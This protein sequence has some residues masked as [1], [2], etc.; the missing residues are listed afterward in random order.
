MTKISHNAE[1]VRPRYTAI[2]ALVIDCP[3]DDEARKV[4]EQ[5]LRQIVD[6]LQVEGADHPRELHLMGLFGDGWLK[7]SGL[8]F[9]INRREDV[10]SGDWS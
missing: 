6:T 10:D 1:G 4:S 2:F 8:H 7:Y 9:D 3:S 5:H